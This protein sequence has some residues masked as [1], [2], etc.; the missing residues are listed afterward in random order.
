MRILIAEDSSDDALIIRSAFQ[1]AGVPAELHFA[2]SG[3]EVLERLQHPSQGNKSSAG[4]DLML[5]DLKMPGMDGFQVLKWLR[6]HPPY[7]RIPAIVFS[8]S[9]QPVDIN[10]A[11]ELGA[12]RYLVKPQ[13]TSDMVQLVRGIEK[14]W[15]KL[16]AEAGAEVPSNQR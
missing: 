2:G 9:D 14:F 5:L 8:G 15:H 4:T 7:D 1:Q 3:E 6:A 13:K 16:Q 10:R 11:L 12:V